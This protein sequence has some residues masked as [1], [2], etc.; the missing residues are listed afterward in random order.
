[1]FNGFLALIWGVLPFLKELIL[2]NQTVRDTLMKNKLVVFLAL[3]FLFVMGSNFYMED[4][5]K[6]L[7]NQN[8]TLSKQ[9]VDASSQ[10]SKCP[11][12]LTPATVAT[13]KLSPVPASTAP[14]L[15]PPMVATPNVAVAHTGVPVP[16]TK[17]QEIAALKTQL[18]QAQR[19]SHSSRSDSP[20]SVPND[21]LD[22]LY[23]KNP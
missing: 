22:K 9:L 17:D 5:A 14:T 7:K 12:V 4:T 3:L 23:E 8:T 20:T 1:M 10:A 2:G 6:Y 19:K 15:V 21:P 18:Q 11:S 16:D 13:T